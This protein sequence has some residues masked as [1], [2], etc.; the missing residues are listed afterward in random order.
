MRN[1]WN[2]LT[3]KLENIQKYTEIENLITSDTLKIAPDM[4]EASCKFGCYLIQVKC[5]MFMRV[6]HEPSG[7]V[8]KY[9]EVFVTELTG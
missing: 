2:D 1:L 4:K 6:F 5:I 8:G 7:C 9:I 3:I